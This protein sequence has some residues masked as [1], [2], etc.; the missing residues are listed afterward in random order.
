MQTRNVV[1][2]LHIKLSRI[3]SAPR[4][5]FIARLRSSFTTSKK[6]FCCLL[7]SKFPVQ[8]STAVPKT[9]SAE[10]Q[11]KLKKNNKKTQKFKK[12]RNKGI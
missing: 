3:L 2:Y 11:Q 6:D 8:K 9:R 10:S 7:L 4:M 5:P 12:Y 1:D